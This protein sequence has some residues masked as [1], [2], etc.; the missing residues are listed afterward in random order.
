MIDDEAPMIVG[1]PALGA[2]IAQFAFWVLLMLG[3][4][5]GELSRRTVVVVV[6]L[7][8]LGF[9]GLPRVP[10]YGGFFVAPYT[11]LLDI[12]LVWLVFKGDPRLTGN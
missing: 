11:A 5:V 3:V 4:F 7:W 9:F 6:A 2:W 8:A 1:S 12:A 10:A